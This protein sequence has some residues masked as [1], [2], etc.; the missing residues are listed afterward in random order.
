MILYQYRGELND[1]SIGYLRSLLTEGAMRFTRPSEFNDP[2]D[3]SPTQFEELPDDAFPH[4]VG[5]ALNRG[6]QNATSTIHG[7][8]CFSPHAKSMCMWSHY[9]DQHRSV[10]VGLDSVE[11]Q[12]QVP[13][14]D[15]GRPAYNGPHK[16]TYSPTRPTSRAG[17]ELF[18]TKSSDWAYE[19]EYRL[20][21]TMQPGK[22]AWGPGVWNIPRS[23]LKEIVLGARMEKQMQ[24]RVVRL[25]Q[26]ILPNIVIRKVVPNMKT[27][28]LMV[29]SLDAQPKVDVPVGYVRGPDGKWLNVDGEAQKEPQEGGKQP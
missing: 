8:A 7:V 14:N 4:A 11:L 17:T 5:D 15:A 2:F 27:F 1:V 6:L 22:P 26:N 12:N 25:V 21:S 24:A 3:C 18:T 13:T 16:V 19:D 29:E 10:C 20:I 23:A 28:E 9:G